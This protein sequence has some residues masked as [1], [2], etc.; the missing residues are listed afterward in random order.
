MVPTL[1]PFTGPT[2]H[3]PR[4][5]PPPPPLPPPLWCGVLGVWCCLPPL[6]Q[7]LLSSSPLLCFNGDQ[8]RASY[9]VSQVTLEAFLSLFFDTQV[10]SVGNYIYIYIRECIHKIR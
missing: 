9:G 8:F 5:G 2:A 1:A 7:T 3:R 6:R 4:C 10:F